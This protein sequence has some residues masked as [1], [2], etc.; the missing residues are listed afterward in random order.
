M[1]GVWSGIDM[2]IEAGRGSGPDDRQQPDTDRPIGDGHHGAAVERIA[3][4][5]P[6]GL[7]Q[8]RETGG[9]ETLLSDSYH[10]RAA[11]TA[12]RKQRMEI[13]VERDTDPRFGC[14]SPQNIP[15]RP[16]GSCRC[17][18]RGPRPSRPVRAKRRLTAAGPGRA[19]GVSS[20]LERL[21]AF[22][23]VLGGEFQCLADILRFQLGI[24]PAQIVPVRRDR[25]RF[26]HT[27]HRQAHAAGVGRLTV[28]DRRN[29]G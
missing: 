22:V 13:R 19:A 26:D 15:C 23:Q 25:E 9:A 3:N 12:G 2:P 11:R 8:R 10:G 16:R 17:R 1:A 20:G 7:Q 5:G 4:A 27:P 29:A 24:F 6:D 18:I 14:R 21:H 28:E